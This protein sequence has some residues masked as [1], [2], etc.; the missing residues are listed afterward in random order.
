VQLATLDAKRAQI[1]ASEADAFKN[2]RLGLAA[3]RENAPRQATIAELNTMAKGMIDSGMEDPDAPGTPLTY[4][5]ALAIARSEAA[6]MPYK[7]AAD[8]L[9]EA[10]AANQP[11]TAPAP[12][13]SP[14]TPSRGLFTDPQGRTQLLQ[15][16][17]DL[18]SWR[19]RLVQEQNAADAAGGLTGGF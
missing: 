19:R 5:K 18:N 6:G 4:T 2:R 11:A 8:R 3:G 10:M 12:R 7:S 13:T 1:A 9:I 16:L 15:P 14:A 17:S